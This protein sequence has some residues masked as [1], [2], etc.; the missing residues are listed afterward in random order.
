MWSYVLT[1][2]YKKCKSEDATKTGKLIP[3]R[4][5]LLFF[6]DLPSLRGEITAHPSD[7]ESSGLGIGWGA[8]NITP[9]IFTNLWR[10][11]RHTQG[12]CVSKEEEEDEEDVNIYNFDIFSL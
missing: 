9:E 3:I 2:S 4:F 5:Q 10:R 11:S 1:I 7:T 6:K 12:C 8:H